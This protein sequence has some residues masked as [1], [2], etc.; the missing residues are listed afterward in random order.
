MS[1]SPL[2]GLFSMTEQR[3]HDNKF[4]AKWVMCPTCR[5]HTDFENIAYADDG[6]NETFSSSV[7]HT[8]QGYA[9]SEAS[10]FVQGSY[11]TKVCFLLMPY[12]KLVGYWCHINVNLG[13]S[14]D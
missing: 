13:Y 12:H 11:G 6:Q 1:H 4:Q 3:V 8:N 7:G 5:Q 2:A 10:M 14:E 9:M